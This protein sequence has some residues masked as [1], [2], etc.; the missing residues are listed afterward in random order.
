[1]GIAQVIAE[2]QRLQA[3]LAERDQ[4]LV[5]RD[6]A[7][8]AREAAL[9]ES[10]ARIEALIASNEQL[11]RA[12]ELLNIQRKG[13]KSE[14][15]VDDPQV[16]LAFGDDAPEPPPR[17]PPAEAPEAPEE[18]ARRKPRKKRAR[19]GRRDLAE[20]TDLPTRTVPSRVGIDETCRRCKKSLRV[21]G[22]DR[23][24]RLDWVPGHFERVEVLRER[25]VC[26]DCPSEGVLTAPEPSFALQQSMCGDGLLA[27]IIVDKFADHVPLHRQAARMRRQGVELATSTLCGWVQAGAE[28]L[29]PIVEAIRARLMASAWLQGDDTGLPVQDG[30]NGAL[31]KGRL[32]AFTDQAEVLYA[33]TDTK[34]GEHPAKLLAN[35]KGRLL[36]CD[37]GSE[38]N[39]VVRDR[40][41]DRAGCWSHLRRG[42]FEA[43]H[44]HP[45]EARLALGTL[46]DLFA[47]EARVW[48][49]DLAT[50]AEVRAREARP[51]VEGFFRW[52]TEL[53]RTVRPKSALGRAIGYA[54]NG[55]ASFEAFLDHPELPMHNNLSELQLRQGVVGRKNWLFAG[56]TGG[57]E[58]AAT[59]YTLIGSCIL[60]GIDPWVYLVDVL[61]K[62][63]DWPA[64]RVAE[65]T[66]LGWRRAHEAAP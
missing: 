44:D 52:L 11:A 21:I 31:R 57:A 65:L 62:L 33:F 56:S 23:S 40:G 8:V 46:R 29:K 12:L 10:L 6:Q 37:G 30:A 19:G 41:L 59:L 4:A 17:L 53:S 54:L 18:P 42:F 24:W 26:P 55:K 51:L 45:N 66:P 47:I 58:A 50:R 9:A 7:L 22:V 2:N 64:K 49:A 5:A 34:E 48:P 35:F 43:R 14:C 38:F 60:Q 20:R 63:A 28:A 16:P 36:L 25:C 13:P 27:A 15:Y 1:M 39:K 3:Q 61:G 32:W